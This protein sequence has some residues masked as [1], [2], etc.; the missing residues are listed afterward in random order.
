MNIILS[1]IGKLP[2]YIIDCIYQIRL[3]YNGNIYLILN[4]YNSEH[5][6]ELKKYNINFIKYEDVFDINF[7]NNMNNNIKNFWYYLDWVV[8][9]EQLFTRSIERF[10]L[11]NNLINLLDLKDNIFM[12]IDILI[13]SDPN[14]WVKQFSIKD[15]GYMAHSSDH[16]N[17]GVFYIKDKNSLKEILDYTIIYIQNAQYKDCPNEMKAL[18]NYYIKNPDKIYLF[19]LMY[20]DDINNIDIIANENYIDSIFDGAAFGIYLLGED[21]IHNKGV[22]VYNKTFDHFIIKAK[23]YKLKWDIID[24]LKKPFIYNPKNDNWILINNLHVHS[25][26]LKSGISR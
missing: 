14:L 12:E 3:Y 21:P 23:N 2:V 19:P 18:Y 4:D 26:D 7:S 13:Y 9:R 5:L 25:K 10:F 11:A 15:V 24:G 16:S 8:E 1:F 20:N 17:S 22:I 6:N